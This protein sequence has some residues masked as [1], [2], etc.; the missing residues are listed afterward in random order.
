MRNKVHVESG[1]HR[2]FMMLTQLHVQNY[3]CN[4]N[5]SQT[6]LFSTDHVVTTC[7]IIKDCCC[8]HMLQTQNR[9]SNL[10][11]FEKGSCCNFVLLHFIKYFSQP[12]IRKR[13]IGI[14]ERNLALIRKFSTFIKLVKSIFIFP[15]S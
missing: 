10:S 12:K 6:F 5:I 2:S 4:F 1:S 9:L 11:C 14:T 7:Q 8:L 3:L 15:C 13:T